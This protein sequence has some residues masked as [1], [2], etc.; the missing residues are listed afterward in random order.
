MA[1][2]ID[3]ASLYTLRSD[4]RYQGYWN[5]TS[6]KRH[7]ICDRDPQKLYCKIA[8]REAPQA[9]TFGE[10]A[11]TW[12]LEVFDNA[13]PGT[14][15]CYSKPLERAKDEF[16]DIPAADL[17]APEIFKLLDRM[18]KQG[19]ASKTVKMQLTVV[20]QIYKYAL[21]HPKYGEELRYNPAD[22]VSLPQKM[23]KAQRREA[24]EDEVVSAIRCKAGTAYFG[25]FALFLLSTGFRRGEALAVQWGN[26][27]LKAKTISCSGGVVY[28][29]GKAVV[30]DTKTESG[31]R[32]VPILPDLESAL[33]VLH[34]AERPNGAHY[35]FHGEDAM[36]PMPE[37][38]F[39]RRWN[40]YCKD[41]GF[42]NTEDEARV[43]KQGKRY[44][45]TT[46]SN[47]LTP[48]VLRHGY[49]TLLF[50]ADVDVYTAK[51]L[52]GHADISTT[53]SVYTHLRERK[54]QASINKLI[55]SV[56]SSMS[57]SDK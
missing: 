1:K 25:L 23:K 33:M 44:T 2:K 38:T 39:R 13:K 26:I 19:Y 48:H 14:Q 45:Y 50:E 29:N 11:D 52:L 27:D 36:A 49:A 31:I 30:G 16:G 47:T 4:G 6:G 28:R 54:K 3:Y 51:K 43:S 12:E 22:A 5:D 20:R 18:A 46:Y 57:A 34:K 55:S 40:H 15:A 9:L 41:M 42:V 35:L 21:V 56:Q 24:P 17:T 7:T 10:I 53:M 32:E 8:E 37:S